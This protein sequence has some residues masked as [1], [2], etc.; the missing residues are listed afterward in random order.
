[1]Q[2]LLGAVS[3]FVLT[4]AEVAEGRALQTRCFVGGA[5]QNAIPRSHMRGLS[6]HTAVWKYRCSSGLSIGS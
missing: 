6:S 4:V 5:A 1:M 3:T 2:A